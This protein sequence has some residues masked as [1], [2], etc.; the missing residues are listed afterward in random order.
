M[1]SCCALAAHPLRTR[2]ALSRYALP[3]AGRPKRR[4]KAKYRIACIKHQR[5]VN[6]DFSEAAPLFVLAV[7]ASC[8]QCAGNLLA[9]HFQTESGAQ[10]CLSDLA[11]KAVGGVVQRNPPIA[12]TFDKKNK[13]WPQ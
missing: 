10:L 5:G 7:R 2:C 13:M 3:Q 1:S 9:A 12:V 11:D 6:V 8:Q 4:A